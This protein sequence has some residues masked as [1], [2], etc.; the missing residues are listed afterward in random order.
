MTVNESLGRAFLQTLVSDGKVVISEDNTMYA[1]AD[2]LAVRRIVE[3]KFL[4]HIS[5]E[6]NLDPSNSGFLESLRTPKNL[7]YRNIL[8]DKGLVKMT[9]DGPVFTDLGEEYME[10]IAK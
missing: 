7:P 9:R 6:V 1:V 5:I 4:N 8:E 2:D 3:L 10:A